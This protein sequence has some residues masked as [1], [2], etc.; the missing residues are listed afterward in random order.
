MSKVYVFLAEGFE[1]VEALSPVDVLK[2]AG[3]ETELVSVTGSGAVTG[4][5]GITIMADRLFE[6]ADFGDADVLILP[7]G[8]PGTLNLEAHEGLVSLLKTHYAES[9]KIAAICAAP[10]ILG[11]LGILEG[12]RA[13]CYPGF[14][15]RLLGA[16]I[17]EDKVVTDG[18][19]TTARGMGAGIA[20]GLALAAQLTD[21]ETAERIKKGIIYGHS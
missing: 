3:V 2:R 15:D 11:K 8:M 9:K 5:H 17:C 14:E 6:E 12:R 7:G 16:Q 13:T 10:S 19:I 18:N 21:R 4:S 20:F 1:E